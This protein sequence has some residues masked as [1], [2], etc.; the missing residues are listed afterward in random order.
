[1]KIERV[2]T[3]QM[4]GADFDY[5]VRRR[6]SRVIIDCEMPAS[7]KAIVRR[8]DEV[9]AGKSTAG[10]DR[11]GVTQAIGFRADSED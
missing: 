9:V 3:V 10:P 5:V 8:I 7:A 4:D 11:E 1:M 6:G 2:I